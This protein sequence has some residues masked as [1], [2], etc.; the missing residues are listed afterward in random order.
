MQAASTEFVADGVDPRVALEGTLPVS[1][2][3][4]PATLPSRAPNPLPLSIWADASLRSLL[5]RDF[6]GV[7]HSRM[8]C[9]HDWARQQMW[10]QAQLSMRG[11]KA[12]AISSFTRASRSSSRWV[13]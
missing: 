7:V 8:P 4:L 9:A 2:P 13:G 1:M 10:A 12:C 6:E 11:V 3:S 5:R